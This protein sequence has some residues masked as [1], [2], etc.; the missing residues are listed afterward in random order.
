MLSDV[1]GLYDRDPRDP[2]AQL[3][4]EVV[5][6]NEQRVAQ[7]FW[8]KIRKVATR[9]PFAADALSVWW[10]ARDPDTPKAAKGMMLA[11]LALFG[12]Y[13]R[14]SVGGPPI[15]TDAANGNLRPLAPVAN[16]ISVSEVE[17][18]LSTVMELNVASTFRDSIFCRF[19]AEILASVKI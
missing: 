15:Y 12:A 9:I 2:E 17:V 13:D 7:G 5:K 16:T 14:N 8:P 18:S 6:V 10:C 19:A 1:D 3:V 11:A 4:P